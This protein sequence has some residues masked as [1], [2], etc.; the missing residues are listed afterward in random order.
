MKTCTTCGINKDISEFYGDK[1]AK[2][3]L[4]SACKICTRIDNNNRNLKN[5]DN[6]QAYGH[7]WYEANKDRRKLSVAAW[8]QANRD[9]MRSYDH[10][11]R[12]RE[13]NAEGHF[14]D[15]DIQR[16]YTEQSA[17]CYYCNC[18]I[19]NEYHI[20]HKTPLCR[21]GTNWPDNICLSCPHCNL[22]KGSKTEEEF[23]GYLL[24]L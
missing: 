1:R 18:S 22:S 3:G 17:I 6:M 7:A 9:K 19:I 11:R 13:L 21:G 24:N 8:Q 2:D 4:R 12:V 16:L 23:M 10:S 14:S 5:S 15:E 20:E